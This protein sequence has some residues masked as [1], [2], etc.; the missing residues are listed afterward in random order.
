MSMAVRQL[1][2]NNDNRWDFLAGVLPYRINPTD[3]DLMFERRGWFLVLEGK[4]EGAP[5]GIGQRRFYDALNA[6][7]QFTIVHFYGTP[8][9]EITAFARWGREAHPGTTEELRSAVRAWFDWVERQI[10]S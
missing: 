10:A 1:R 9:D 8:P 6:L 3:I 2:T 5:F 4:R 7:P